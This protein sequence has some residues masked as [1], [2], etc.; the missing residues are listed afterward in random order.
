MGGPVCRKH[1]LSLAA[2]YKPKAKFVGIVLPDG[3]PLTRLVDE[4][5]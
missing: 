5:E 4:K 1:E 2:L 3:K